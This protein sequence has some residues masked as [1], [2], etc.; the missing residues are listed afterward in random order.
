M[1][2]SSGDFFWYDVMTTDTKDATD[3]YKSVVGWGTQSSGVEDMSYTL[4]TL[5]KGKG[6]GVAGLMPIPPDA[7]EHGAKPAWNGYVYVDDVDAMTKKVVDAG[8]TV[9]HQP[10]DI[11]TVGRF[12]V[13]ADPQGATFS[14]FK[15]MPQDQPVQWPAPGTDRKRG[16]S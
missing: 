8:G 15:P 12:S 1:A 3:F 4:L 10:D 14:L 13:V 9:H 6:M 5:D 2:I 16:V 7:A 11:P